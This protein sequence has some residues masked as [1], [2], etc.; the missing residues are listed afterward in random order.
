MHLFSDGEKNVA[1]FFSFNF[2][3]LLAS[4][5][6]ASLAHR[7][8]HSV[9]SWDRSSNF[10]AFGFTLLRITWASHSRRWIL[11]SNVAW[12]TTALVNQSNTSDWFRYVWALPKNRWRPRRLHILRYA[13]QVWCNFQQ[14]HCTFVT[15]RSPTGRSVLSDMDDDD[16]P[17]GKPSRWEWWTCT[18]CASRRISSI[19]VSSYSASSENPC[20]ENGGEVRD[21][22]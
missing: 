9:S 7:S 14:S 1:L 22:V 5:H 6:A 3:M 20:L 12:R 13:T 11:V 2:R 10:G 4:F 8:C 16:W 15:I 21:S 18:R 17:T 19:A